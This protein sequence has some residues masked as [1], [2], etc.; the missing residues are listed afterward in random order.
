MSVQAIAWVLEK[1]QSRLAA[2][3][4]LLAI[5]N[6]A[7]ADGV[8]SW[9]SVRAIAREARITERQVQ[10]CLPSLIA[11]G[12]LKMLIG[13]GPH[14]TNSYA[15]PALAA[16]RGGDNLSPPTNGKCHPPGDKSD[17]AIRKNRPLTVQTLNPPAPA[18]A[19]G[20]IPG[21]RNRDLLRIDQEVRQIARAVPGIS[22][23]EAVEMAAINLGFNP[24]YVAWSGQAGDC[25]FHPGSGATPTGGCWGCYAEQFNPPIDTEREATQ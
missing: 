13:M 9:P 12:E 15:I 8:D 6:H 2:R 4:V 20:R 17:G 14:G 7:D 3:L 23:A 11:L 18:S 5:A 19:G 21:N 22:V 24:A 10:R 1:S 25:P 16:T